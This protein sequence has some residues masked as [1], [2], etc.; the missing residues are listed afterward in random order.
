MRTDYTMH[1]ITDDL[2]D[3][4]HERLRSFSTNRAVSTANTKVSQV[5]KTP[6]YT[7]RWYPFDGSSQTSTWQKP[8]L[9]QGL[10]M[11]HMLK[12][13]QSFDILP[14]LPA[15][16]TFNSQKLHELQHEADLFRSRSKIT[17]PLVH[18]RSEYSAL[19]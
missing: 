2:H 19:Q 17:K 1:V 15:A 13:V 11:H 18:Y 14:N 10:T 16:K 5:L 7:N 4:T 8:N 9:G 6:Y 12:H 3:L